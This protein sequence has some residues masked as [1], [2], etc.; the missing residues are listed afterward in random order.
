M[1]DLSQ[2]KTL[3]LD[4]DGKVLNLRFNR[5]EAANAFSPEMESEFRR[6]LYE[7]SHD[8]M[9][10]AVVISGVGKV[11]S[12]GGDLDQIRTV[13][14]QPQLFFPSIT[15]A[16]QLIN[17]ILDC[18]KPLIAKL[19]GHAMG[20]GATI[21]LY[22]DICYAAS[23]VRIADPHVVVGFTAGDGGALIWP[24][25]IG[26]NRAKEYLLT[27]DAILAPEA[28]RLGLIN[29]AVPA[30]KLDEQ[31]NELAQRIANGPS[32]AV[33][34]TKASINIGLKQI[35][36]AGMDASI[37]YEALSNVTADHRE[38]VA[39][40]REKRKPSFSGD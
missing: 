19:N 27:G 2:F 14:E 30:E 35:V 28:E 21:A 40:M 10:H 18:P 11:F 23:H 17:L 20:L 15:E 38:A 32:R 6:F 37:A 9:T 31:V 16:K 7:V 13:A 24:Q 39:A 26:F 5:P 29:R 4:R 34:W 25:L 1:R 8:P 12:A 36:A 3:L 33:Q 22:C